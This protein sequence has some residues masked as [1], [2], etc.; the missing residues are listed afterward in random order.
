MS[1][2]VVGATLIVVRPTGATCGFG[3]FCLLDLPTDVAFGTILPPRSTLVATLVYDI[4][5]N[6]GVAGILDFPQRR[7]G[8][9]TLG[10][11]CSS[12]RS[13][14]LRRPHGSRTS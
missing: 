12:A 3:L 2:V 14:P 7:S 11:R 4:V 8:A 10:A 5:E 1:S 9:I 13:L 6:L